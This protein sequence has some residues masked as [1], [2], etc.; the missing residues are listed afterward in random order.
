MH[1]YQLVQRRAE[2][3][4]HAVALGGQDGLAWK[5]LDSSQ[6]LDRVDRLAAELCSQGVGAGD[7]VV[8][9]L[10]NHWRTPV[11]LFALWKLGA[12]IVPFDR[13]M[14]PEAGASILESVEPRLVL[15]GYDERPAWAGGR[16]L[17]DWWEP[18]ARGGAPTAGWE[19]PSED[20]AAIVFTSG[21]TGSP[22]GCMITHANLLSQIE[23]GHERIALDARCRLASILP[24]SH[25]FELTCGLLYPL[26][27]GAAVHYIPSRRGPDIV[28]VLAEQRVTHMMAVPQLLAMMGHALDQ[29]LQ[30]ALPPQVYAGLFR[31]TDRLP[32][33]ARRRV[34]WMVHRKLGGNA[35]V[36][37][38]SRG[39]APA[40]ARRS[41][42]AVGT[43][44][45][46]RLAALAQP[47][48]ASRSS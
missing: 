18:G 5:T 31:L 44:A 21:T 11:Y 34:F 35:W 2:R 32:L 15:V 8:L 25:L 10:P 24:L 43:T 33:E 6:L 7:R 23:A 12:I 13:E 20:L 30:A 22:K 4:P 28:R 37:V 3:L 16:D 17:V 36:C 9:W 19:P 26:D 41:L 1:L 48:K 40:N 27:A 42:P 45:Q 39:M 14:N 38:W 47:S 46:P 29:Q